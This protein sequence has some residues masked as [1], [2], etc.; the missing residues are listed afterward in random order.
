M[1]RPPY[2]GCLGTCASTRQPRRRRWPGSGASPCAVLR[3]RT[4]LLRWWPPR[5]LA[6]AHQALAADRPTWRRGPAGLRPPT[7][8]LPEPPRPALP[9]IEPGSLSRIGRDEI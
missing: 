4:A 7:G 6:G 8:R 3:F 1:T 2:A 5:E 9:G